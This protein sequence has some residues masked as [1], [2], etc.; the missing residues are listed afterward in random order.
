MACKDARKENMIVCRMRR[1]F[2][3]YTT[4]RLTKASSGTDSGAEQGL[5]SLFLES[6]E[7]DI[8]YYFLVNSIFGLN[9][10]CLGCASSSLEAVIII[11]LH[12]PLKVQLLPL[13]DLTS[14]WQV[15][16]L[17]SNIFVLICSTLSYREFGFLLQPFHSQVW[18]KN[19]KNISSCKYMTIVCYYYYCCLWQFSLPDFFGCVL[20]PLCLCLI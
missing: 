20:S 5:L 19:K 9:S 18:F 6:L 16:L 11:V 8:E 17:I 3:S 2:S 7:Q 12:W 14:N 4:H 15:L 10:T 1:R 13:L